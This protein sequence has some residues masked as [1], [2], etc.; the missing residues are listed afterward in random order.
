[1][2]NARCTIR[3]RFLCTKNY[4][5]RDNAGN[6]TDETVYQILVFDGDNAVKITGVD[7]KDMKFGQEIEVLC[8]I[9]SGDYGVMFRAVTSST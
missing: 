5:K 4:K 3:G 2:A 6:Y 9:Y 7:A 1:M 8:D